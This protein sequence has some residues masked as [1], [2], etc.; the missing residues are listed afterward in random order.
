MTQYLDSLTS[1]AS[2][3][4]AIVLDQWGV[5][6]DGVNPYPHA[7]G[8]LQEMTAQGMRFGVL[9]NSGKRSGPNAE[10]IASM[11]FDRGLFE[12]VMTSGEALWQDMAAG[13]IPEKRFLPIESTPGDAAIFA[14]G[15]DIAMTEDMA[16]AE[17]ILLM[18]LPD[19]GDPAAWDADFAHALETGK[20]VYCSN[21]DRASPRGADIVISPGALAHAH[22]DKSG[23]VVFYG[24]P[25]RPIFEALESA[26]GTK[27][28]LMVGDSLEHDIAGGKGAGWHA[29]LIQNGLYAAEFAAENSDA[30]LAR[31]MAEKSA[32]APDYRLD[33]LQ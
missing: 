22:A 32:P 14:D 10:R 17:A 25:H 29:A 1:V 31:L 6:H 7:N 28:L 23:R 16:E 11:G 12:V 2:Q 18:G 21:P 3:F 24:K 33:W 30:T 5:L 8:F 15:L 13:R 26:L 27:R 4:D 19:G 9:S 20:P